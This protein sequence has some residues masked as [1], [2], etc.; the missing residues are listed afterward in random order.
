MNLYCI[1]IKLSAVSPN[2]TRALNNKAHALDG[3]RKHNE[4]YIVF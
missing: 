1:L 4:S 2:D 3:L